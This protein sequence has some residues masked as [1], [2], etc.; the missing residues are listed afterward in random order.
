MKRQA[1]GCVALAL[2]LAFTV[3][4]T[5]S[6]AKLAGKEVQLG[7]IDPF[8]GWAAEWGQTNAITMEIALEEIN[9][10]G[11]VGGV[12][13]R[14]IK[15]DSASKP[16]D[17]IN[18][19]RRLI[20]QDKALAILG[21]FLSSSVKMA[22]PVANRAGIVMISGTSAAPG[23]A[24]ENRPWTFRN[25]MTSDR[26]VGPTLE[27]YLKRYPN[28]KKVALLYD[29]K[30][31][32]SKT[33]ATAVFP[34][35]LQQRGIEIVS[36]LTFATG[37]VD[38]SAQATKVKFAAPDGI[39]LCAVQYE[40]ANLIKE[41][42]RQGLQQPVVMGIG[43]SAWGFIR[44]GGEAVE[45]TIMPTYFWLGNPDPR[46]QA[47]IKK[48]KERTKQDPPHYTAS[49]YDTIYMLKQ[50]VEMSGVTN[51]PEDLQADRQKIRDYLTNLKGFPGITGKTDI[52]ADGDADKEN[53]VV[54]VKKGEFIRIP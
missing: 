26:I 48:F 27:R 31:V 25:V 3:V 35:L 9:G 6:A 32:V 7:W 12:P 2:L 21:P 39:V 10:E 51:K 33:E 20:E 1:F 23:I 42:R 29:N 30:D 47:F 17:A 49:V 43:S 15:Y 52:R 37:D 41:I 28:I 18:A 22:F 46:A 5:A 38:F 16:T 4:M 36:T 34:A 53:Y 54:E 24:A 13:L 14:F 19:A 50:A 45:G 11:G 8:S 40:G 44:Q